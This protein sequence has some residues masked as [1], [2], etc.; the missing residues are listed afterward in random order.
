MKLSKSKDSDLILIGKS[1]IHGKGVFAA[2]EISKGTEVIEYT[3]EKI[4]KNEGDRRSDQQLKQGKLYVFELNKKYDIDGLSGGSDAHLINHSCDPNCE[5]INF[6]DQ[7][8]WIVAIKNIPK[9]TEL[10]Y[11][12]E[13]TGEKEVICKCGSNKCRKNL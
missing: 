5:S 1:K 13:L 3:G 9:G 7:N 8:I 2:K 6:D 11:D 10:T 12:Y 4:S